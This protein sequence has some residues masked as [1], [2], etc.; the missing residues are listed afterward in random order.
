MADDA[1]VDF[2]TVANVTSGN[3]LRWNVIDRVQTFTAPLWVLVLSAVTWISPTI[4]LNALALDGIFALATILLVCCSASNVPTAAAAVLALSLSRAF[5]DYSMAGLPDA[6]VYLLLACGLFACWQ[7]SDRPKWIACV[8]GLMPLASVPVALVL[9]PSVARTLASETQTS[10]RRALFLIAAPSVLWSGFAIFYYGVPLPAPF[11]A[12][13][14]HSHAWLSMAAEGTRYVLRS[15]RG[16]PITPI[17]IVAAIAVGLRNRTRRDLP[18]TIG[19]VAYTAWVIA[20]GGSAPG[21]RLL[22]PAALASVMLLAR[23]RRLPEGNAG[24]ATLLAVVAVGTFAASPTFLSDTPFGVNSSAS[25]SR[26]TRDER[27]SIYQKTGLLCATRYNPYPDLTG[28]E[29]EIERRLRDNAGVA[30]TPEIGMLGYAAGARL[31]IVD[32]NGRTDLRFLSPHDA[33]A[34]ARQPL[35]S[36]ARLGTVLRLNLSTFGGLR[37]VHPG[38]GGQ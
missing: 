23:S 12:A 5:V 16:D 1:F 21:G 32:P 18:E 24:L 22:A 37:V 17:L 14:F 19:L 9:A 33:D 36:G 15:L 34:L 25:K 30:V 3:G 29:P 2:R 13:W 11:Y 20:S 38:V 35:F 10:R 8:A 6:L 26:A 27:Q 4:P 31:S 28:L 7:A